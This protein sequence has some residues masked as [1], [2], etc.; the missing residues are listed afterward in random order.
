MSTT[1]DTPARDGGP[2]AIAAPPHVTTRIQRADP[3]ALAALGEFSSATIH[4]AQGRRGAIASNIKPVDRNMRFFGSA[5]TVVCAPRDNL[6]L[7]VAIHYAQPGDVLLVSAGE[8]VQA[9]TFGDVLGNACK[10]KGIAAMVTDSG[11]RDTADLRALGL[12]VFSAGVSITG[13]V[14]ET[15]GPVNQPLVFGGQLVYPGDALVGDGDGVVVVRREEIP[16]V[17]ELA[18][19]RFAA[20]ETLIGQYRA[21]GTTIDLCNLRDVLRAK[22]LTTDLDDIDPD[23]GLGASR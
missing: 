16:T 1:I 7:Q 20:E 3:A 23:Q 4:E 8:M 5:F 2:A 15:L 17:T 12:P 14:K 13:T 21:G 18:R 19:A 6:M 9:G 22:G 10:A 11:V